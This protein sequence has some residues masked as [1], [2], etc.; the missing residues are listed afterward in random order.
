MSRLFK[1]IQNA[2]I[3]PQEDV[4]IQIYPQMNKLQKS[5]KQV[6]YG[7]L[8]G[9]I[10]FC[11]GG[12]LAYLIVDNSDSFYVKTPQVGKTE[13]NNCKEKV[14]EATIVSINSSASE[15]KVNQEISVEKEPIS[16]N[17]SLRIWMNKKLQDPMLK[18]ENVARIVK[19]MGANLVTEMDVPLNDDND[20]E[21]ALTPRQKEHLRCI[22][23]FLKRFKIE[24]V[25]IDGEQSR[26]QA[27]GHAYVLNTLVS[28]YPKLR[29][30]GINN[31]E[32]VFR[33]EYNQE[34]RKEISQYE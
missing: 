9:F 27:N 15:A 26:V 3:F 25:R 16:L 19:D 21:I 10:F 14:K 11:L 29:L 31:D 5:K 34:Y 6:N 30:A 32:I 22:Q 28:Q 7:V 24:C 17:Q 4:K 23:D 1:K 33:D 2:S 18:E 8:V 13:M 20:K 12:L